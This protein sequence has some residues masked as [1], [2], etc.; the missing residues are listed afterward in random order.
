MASFFTELKRRNVFK[1][2]VAYVVVAWLLLQLTDIVLPT[3]NAPSWVA[4]TITFVLLLGFPVAVFFAWAFELTPEGLK[5]THEV[6][7][8]ESITHVTGRKLDFIIIGVMG[9][10]IVFLVVNRS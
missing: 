6:E 10:A 9:L 5:P 8:S 2:G 1:V 3:F 4:Q 7:Q